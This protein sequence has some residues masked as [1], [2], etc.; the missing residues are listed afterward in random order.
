M[1]VIFLD[2]DGVLNSQGSF[3]YETARRKKH[4]EQGVSGPVNQTLC[5]VCTANFQRILDQYPDVKI[6]LSTTWR[7][8]F[9]IDWLKAKLA[10]YHVDGS[11]VIGKTPDL[12]WKSRG[13]EIQQWLDEHPEVTHYV[14]IDDNA[15]EID[16][17][18]GS[19][20]FVHTSWGGGLTFDHAEEVINKLTNA[21]R[22][23]IA[24]KKN[25]P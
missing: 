20:R 23:F 14:A 10:E 9:D 5:N 2:F 19:E 13:Q 25:V 17:I 4:K 18:H 22:D 11:R 15:D 6:V 24:E 7:I 21:N 1:K 3:I 12:Q 16:I 8:L